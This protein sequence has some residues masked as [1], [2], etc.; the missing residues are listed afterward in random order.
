MK[1]LWTASV[2]IIII[3]NCNIYSQETEKPFDFPHKTGDMFQYFCEDGPGWYDTIQIFTVFDSTDGK[4][5]I[6]MK[7]KAYML[8]PFRAPD[9]FSASDYYYWI[10]TVDQA[11]YGWG[12]N[13]DSTLLFKLNG[14][15]GDIWIDTLNNELVKVR[16]KWTQDVWGKEV[17]IMEIVHYRPGNL[18]DTLTWLDVFWLSVADGYGIVWRAAGW[19]LTLMGAVIDGTVYGDTTLVTSVRNNTGIPGSI[20][21]NQNYPNPFNPATTISF[22]IKER[23][24]ILLI[25]YDVT[26]REVRRLIDNNE[27][28]AGGH[29]IMWD[30]SN[31]SNNPV[32]SGVYF[33]RLIAGEAVI[34][35]TMILMK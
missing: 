35:R 5:I 6:H 14:K 19:S 31:E 17:S 15:I 4:G 9:H 8:N 28:E 13:T 7:Q 29:K 27:Y 25:I 34:T 23:N 16:D 26:G 32:S 12:I 21:L 3:L 30:G 1:F 10:D 2:C 22:E 33:Y 11:V 18:N 20:K 24:N